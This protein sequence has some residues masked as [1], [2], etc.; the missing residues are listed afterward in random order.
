MS[1]RKL[2]KFAAFAGFANTYT[3]AD[4]GAIPISH[5]NTRNLPVT[6]ELASGTGAYTVEMARRYPDRFFI[7]MDI[8]GSRM[9][10][11]AER[12]LTEGLHNVLFIR[13]Q[14]ERLDDL[15][16]ENSISDIWITFADP[17]LAKGKERKRLTYKRFLKMYARCMQAGGKLHLKTDS[18]ELF[19]YSLES[20]PA[21]EEEGVAPFSLTCVIQNVY[22]EQEVPDILTSIQT[23]Y[24]ISHLKEGRTIRYL[25]AEKQ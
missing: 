25:Q 5:W 14:I 16:E 18:I 8:K 1:R 12:A 22:T 15:L 4:D 17:F 2:Q 9:W 10:K 3:P 11:G 13:T 7:G 23:T 24:E 21:F 20:I 6:L 19:E